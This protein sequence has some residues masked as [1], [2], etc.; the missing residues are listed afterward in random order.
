MRLSFS[1]RLA[2]ALMLLALGGYATAQER[3]TLRIADQ[4]G[5]MRS[6][7]EAANALQNL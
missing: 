5:G 6:Q 2:A 1:G 4:K 7:L 3:L